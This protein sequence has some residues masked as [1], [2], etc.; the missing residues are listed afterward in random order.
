MK[1]KYFVY[2]SIVHGKNFRDNRLKQCD[3]VVEISRTDYVIL[4]QLTAISLS[5]INVT[6][7]LPMLATQKYIKTVLYVLTAH[8]QIR[9]EGASLVF[10]VYK[11]ERNGAHCYWLIISV[12][13]CSFMC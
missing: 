13:S 6:V 7:Y 5:Q 8:F 11:T 12:F 3:H 10:D 9:K 1:L 2:A 4:T